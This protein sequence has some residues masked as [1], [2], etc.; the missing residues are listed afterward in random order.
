[1]VT[2]EPLFRRARLDDAPQLADLVNFAG[3]GVPLY[4]WGKMAMPGETA[5]D[6]GRRRAARDD[7]GFSWRNAYVADIGGNAVACLIGYGIPDT[8]EP[9]AADTSP[10]FIPLMELE[11]LAPGT[12]YVNVLATYP[13]HRGQGIGSGLL[14][15]AETLAMDDGKRG[16]SVIVSDSNTGAR[17]LYERCGYVE[18]AI[19][20]M[21]KEEWRSESF[22]WILLTKQLKTVVST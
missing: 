21:I 9:I 16:L 14:G 18:I 11:S 12:W 2:L 17:R 4:L 7:G 3:E 19:R 13:E 20:P 5:W 6:V 15:L 10:M 8:P 1:M 22:N